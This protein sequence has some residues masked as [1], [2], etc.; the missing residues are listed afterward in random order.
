[1]NLQLAVKKEYFDQIKSGEKTRE[2]R[3]VNEYWKKRMVKV[4]LFETV[5]ITCGYPKKTDKEKIL[6][7]PW[8]GVIIGNITHPHFGAEPV[9]VYQILLHG[10]IN[11]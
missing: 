4:P 9:L 2:F 1:M 6:V 7:F 11:E 8:N 5:T 3:M 10:G